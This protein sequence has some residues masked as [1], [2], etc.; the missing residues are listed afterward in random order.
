MCQALLLS[1]HVHIWGEPLELLEFL[2]ETQHQVRY[3]IRA[4]LQQPGEAYPYPESVFADVVMHHMAEIGMTF[5]PAVCHYTAKVGNANLRLSGYAIS[6]DA[7]QL[8]LFV[9]LYEGVDEITSISDTETKIAAE[10][11]LRFLVRCAQRRL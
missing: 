1:R 8:D 2:R 3:E 6:D 9:S 10:Q 5:E 11:C 7:D 4:D